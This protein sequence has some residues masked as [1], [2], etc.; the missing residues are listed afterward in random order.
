[1]IVWKLDYTRPAPVFLFELYPHSLFSSEEMQA[2]LL[3]AG[4]WYFPTLGM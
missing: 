1:M 4:G 3:T 2:K